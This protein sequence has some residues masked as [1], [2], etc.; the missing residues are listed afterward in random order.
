VR[1]LKRRI[2]RDALRPN[3][4]RDAAFR[5][6]ILSIPRGSIAT[7]GQVAAAAGYP[8]YH[9]AVAR[10]LRTVPA[11]SLPWQ[12][13]LGAGGAIKLPGAGGAEQRLRLEMEGVTFRGRKANLEAH[14]HVF[15]TW[16]FEE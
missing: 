8:M 9:R 10:L 3:E 12:R 16:D 6:A 13:V 4:L 7:Y 2:D 5:R 11:G 1:D 14:L 15:R